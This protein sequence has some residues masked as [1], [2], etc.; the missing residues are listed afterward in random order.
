M[1]DD[2][3]GMSVLEIYPY[4]KKHGLRTDF[5]ERPASP[6]TSP[7][8]S[9]NSSDLLN[10]IAFFENIKEKRTKWYMSNKRVSL[11]MMAEYDSFLG[12][13]KWAIDCLK[14]GI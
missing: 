8:S 10:A 6:E 13:C 12:K 7:V 9:S 4:A 5:T 11:A 3:P 14:R 1:C 2:Q